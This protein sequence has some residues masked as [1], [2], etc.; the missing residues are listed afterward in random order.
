M[1][2]NFAT[3]SILALLR[4]FTS[5]V[6]NYY[7]H[8]LYPWVALKTIQTSLMLLS[9]VQISDVDLTIS[10]PSKLGKTSSGADCDRGTRRGGMRGRS[11]AT[12]NPSTPVRSRANASLT[13]FGSGDLRLEHKEAPY[14][15][16][17]L[18]W[19]VLAIEH[20]VIIPRPAADQP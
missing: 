18:Y 7:I 10:T 19:C 13:Q 11:K 15:H 16:P 8:L 17:K 20:L 2:Y 3:F 5:F 12:C 4:S 9:N 14:A 6:L 1:N